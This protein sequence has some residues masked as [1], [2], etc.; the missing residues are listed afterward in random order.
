MSVTANPL[1]LPMTLAIASLRYPLYRFAIFGFIGQLVKSM[2]LSFSG[3]YGLNW[4]LDVLGF[5]DTVIIALVIIAGIILLL[6]L[7]QFIVWIFETRDKNRKYKAAEA[8]A[9]KAGKPL[10]VIG[11]PWGVQSAR[12][13]LNIPAHGG[14]DVC[15]DIDRRALEGHTC[16]VVASVTDIPFADKTFGAVFMSHVLEHLPTPDDA[17][18]AL[19]EMQ[20]V[21]E[22][23]HIVYPSRQSIAAWIIKEHKLWVWQAGTQIYLLQRHIRGKREKVVVETANKAD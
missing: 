22:T 6:A 21:G 4:I 5:S 17:R 13:L 18:K 3:Y 15:L 14:G 16:P 1:H 20:R 7:W 10:L 2:V 11:G 8:Y 9:R 19:E 12:R 23:V